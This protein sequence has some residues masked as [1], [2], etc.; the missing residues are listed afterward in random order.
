MASKDP[1]RPNVVFILSDDQGHWAMG[2]AG[3]HEIR[4]P[5]LDRLAAMGTRFERFFC[6]SPVCSPARASLLTGRI[7]SQHGVHDWIR[8]GNTTP[9]PI[10]Y[11]AG[12]LTYTDVLADHGYDCGMVGKWHLGDSARPRKGFSHWFVHEHGGGQY[13]GAPMIREGRVTHEPGY[14]TNVLTEDA[15]SYIDQSAAGDQPF[16]LSVHH[17]APHGPWID[18]HPRSFVDLYQDCPFDTCPQE[19]AHPWEMRS[20]PGETRKRWRES[21]QGYFASVTAMDSDIGRILDRLTDLGLRDSTLIC[22]LSDNG[23]NCG[24]HG[25]W[26][27]GN[28]T[29]PANMYDSSVLVP[30]IMSQ[31][32]RIPEGIVRSELLSGYDIMP[33]LLDYVGLECP[34]EDERPG[35]SFVSLLTAGSPDTSDFVVVHDEYGPARMIR[36]AEWKYVHRYPNGPHE[37]YDLVDDPDERVNLVADTSRRRQVTSLRAELEEWFLRYADQ[38]LDGAHQPVTG[39][40]QRDLVG[41]P[42]RGALAF[43]QDVLR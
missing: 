33:T 17:Y 38:H 31:P 16:Y 39:R 8:E 5:N 19:P 14:L 11:L 35:R 12:Q 10:D 41:P 6:T 27:K 42:P 20:V 1:R 9:R 23:F 40:G 34:D 28:G 3:N 30:A 21:L 22:F 29:L 4:T 36:T 32:G 26:G 18:Q 13:H 43:Y 2:C 25:I 37:L 7:P 24:H 15:L